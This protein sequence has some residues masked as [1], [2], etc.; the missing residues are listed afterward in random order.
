MV[1]NAEKFKEEDE[2]ARRR[3]DAKN[4][5]ENIVYS[6]KNQES[7]SDEVKAKCDEA[8]KWIDANANAT[9]EEFEAYQKEFL[10]SVAPVPPEATPPPATTDPKLEEID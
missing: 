2:K 7:A 8:I 6:T 4:S 10:D 1:A 9:T 5:L 3:V